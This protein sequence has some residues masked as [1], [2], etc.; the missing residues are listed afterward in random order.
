MTV[1][2]AISNMIGFAMLVVMIL[3]FNRRNKR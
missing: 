2:E 1:A 3:E